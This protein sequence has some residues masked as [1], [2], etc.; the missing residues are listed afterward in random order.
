VPEVRRIADFPVLT[1]VE[2]NPH[3][4]RALLVLH[5]VGYLEPD[6]DYGH[7]SSRVKAACARAGW[8]LHVLPHPANR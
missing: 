3:C 5:N 1:G 6:V 2:Y 4:R 8:A 7:L